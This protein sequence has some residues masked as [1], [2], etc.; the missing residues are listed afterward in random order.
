[1]GLIVAS[2]A[3]GP[4]LY[5][6]LALGAF[7]SLL[8]D[9]DFLMF[10]LW[11]RFSFAGH[12]GITHTPIFV[13]A[14]SA[15]IYASLYVIP[16]ISDIGMLLV[17]LLIGALHVLGDY[18][19]TGGVP[20]LYPFT[21]RSFKLNIDLS[22]N[23]LLALFSIAGMVVLIRAYLNYPYF[24]NVRRVTILLGSA[25]IFYYSARVALKLY[26]ERKPENKG[27]SAMPT[28]NP[29]R[30]EYAKRMETKDA[31]E[32]SLKT[33]EEVKTFTIPKAKDKW[34]KIERCEDLVYTYW[35]PLVQREMHFFE[36]PCYRLA[37]RKGRM[38]IVWNSVEA[39]EAIEVQVTIE[40]GNLKVNN[41]FQG[42]KMLWP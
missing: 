21:R 42:K 36:Y 20:L 12:H 9:L 1:M 41:R 3:D 8:P 29:F 31:I 28:I 26:Q 19:G 10:P 39:G 33:K 13:F 37:C 5:L 6:Y 34:K 38:E 23:P 16:K 22:I 14:A 40:N 27:F 18:L 15:I 2:L 7:M 11:K 25:F 24:P 32:I 30:W 17:I 35:H 4:N